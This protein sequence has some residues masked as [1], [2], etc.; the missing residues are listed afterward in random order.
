MPVLT[1][2]SNV[3]DGPAESARRARNRRTARHTFPTRNRCAMRRGPRI[4]TALKRNL[5]A[6]PSRGLQL[7]QRTAARS[8]EQ[9]LHFAEDAHARHH[10]YPTIFPDFDAPSLHLGDFSFSRPVA[11]ALFSRE[12]ATTRILPASTLP[13]KLSRITA[14]HAFSYLRRTPS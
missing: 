11:A 4:A 8:P 2:Q 9:L 6:R 1:R 13:K 5:R 7:S 12:L 10:D 3:D 14:S